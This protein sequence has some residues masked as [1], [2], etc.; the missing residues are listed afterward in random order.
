MSNERAQRLYIARYDEMTLREAVE[1]I[2]RYEGGFFDGDS[3]TVL[4][5]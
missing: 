4:M 2:D 1:M 3:R 5:W